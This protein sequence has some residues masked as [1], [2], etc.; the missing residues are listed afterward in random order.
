MIRVLMNGKNIVGIANDV[1]LFLI[2]INDNIGSFFILFCFFHFVCFDCD[3]HISNFENC[4]QK[5]NIIFILQI[6]K[7]QL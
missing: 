3:H 6:S 2:N 4:D 1:I 7:Y 5:D